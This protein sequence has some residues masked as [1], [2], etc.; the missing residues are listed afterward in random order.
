MLSLDRPERAGQERDSGGHGE[1]DDRAR[2]LPRSRAARVHPVGT[3]T[4]TPIGSSSTV[5]V[6]DTSKPF[7]VEDDSH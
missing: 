7:A 1:A 3:G 2:K 6:I 5:P 4:S